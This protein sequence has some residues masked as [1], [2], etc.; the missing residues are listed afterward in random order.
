MK[1]FNFQVGLYGTSKESEALLR[2]FTMNCLSVSIFTRNNAESLKNEGFSVFYYLDSMINNLLSRKIIFLVGDKSN[3][4]NNNDIVFQL[5]SK[6]P[7]DSI[8]IDFLYKP[9]KLSILNRKK[10]SEKNINYFDARFICNTRDIFQKCQIMISG[11]IELLD[12]IKDVFGHCFSNGI[13]YVDNSY[14]ASFMSHM[15]NISEHCLINIFSEIFNVFNKNGYNQEMFEKYLSIFK[16]SVLK[17]LDVNMENFNKFIFENIMNKNV[18]DVNFFIK[19]QNDNLTDMPLMLNSILWNGF[20][21]ENKI[22]NYYR[23]K[24]EKPTYEF[25]DSYITI[26]EKK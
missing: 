12:E 9:Y 19:N 6:L 17:N 22:K 5:I 3:E 21:K 24:F 4:F 16:D 25:L 10:A 23:N 20:K 18:K 1:G 15:L 11:D 26:K 14:G 7:E 2:N 13:E 8:I